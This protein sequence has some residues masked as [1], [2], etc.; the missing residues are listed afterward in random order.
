MVLSY[1]TTSANVHDSSEVITLL[2]DDDKGKTLYADAGYRGHP[3][4]EG[5]KA[6]N[7]RKSKVRSRV[8]HVFEFM[9][10]G[11][12]GLVVRTVGLARAKANVAL[13]SLVYNACRFCQILHYHGDWLV[14][15]Y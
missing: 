14:A 7:R 1:D 12:C 10:Q 4:T 5:Q 8:E 3:L 6:E 11:M 13:T 9:E 15:T 2:S